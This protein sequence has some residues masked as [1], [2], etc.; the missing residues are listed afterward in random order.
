MKKFLLLPLLAIGIVYALPHIGGGLILY[1]GGSY[2]EGT[3]VT[4]GIFY[5]IYKLF[6]RK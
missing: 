4:G 3:L 5:V 1:S 2:I 6:A